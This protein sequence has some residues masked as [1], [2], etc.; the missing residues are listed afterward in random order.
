MRCYLTDFV[1]F[2]KID[3]S[4]CKRNIYGYKTILKVYMTTYKSFKVIGAR[5][6]FYYANGDI[7][8]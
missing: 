7:F 5:W 2:H 4:S 6:N 8:F 1:G 3:K